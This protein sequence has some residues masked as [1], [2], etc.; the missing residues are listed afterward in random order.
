MY[1]ITPYTHK[2]LLW[3]ITDLCV[4]DKVSF[5]D[6]VDSALWCEQPGNSF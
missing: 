6:M 4:W 1:V 3:M 5:S 2:N